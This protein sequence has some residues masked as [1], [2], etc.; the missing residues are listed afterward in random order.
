MAL[1]L[2]ALLEHCGMVSHATE[3]MQEAGTLEVRPALFY[4]WKNQYPE[5]AAAWAEAVD[6]GADKLEAVA[7]Q[8]AVEG[9]Q[10]PVTFQGEITATYTEYSDGLLQFLLKGAKPDKYN[11]QALQLSGPAGGPIQIQRV[12]RVIVDPAAS[13]AD[14]DDKDEA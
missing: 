6:I 8:R 1:F 2:E 3:A 4:S 9:V 10:K 7:K 12:E 11:R 14:G 13:L 5:F